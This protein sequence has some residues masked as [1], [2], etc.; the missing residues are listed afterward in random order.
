MT[1]RLLYRRHVAD[2]ML[3]GILLAMVLLPAA[4]L[5][6]LPRAAAL[7]M[8]MP[9]S[10]LPRDGLYRRERIPGEV[11]FFSWTD[12]DSLLKPPNPGG[13]IRLRVELLSAAQEPVGV[14]MRA[15]AMTMH[16]VVRPE[17]RSYALL[18]PPADGERIA[19]ALDSPELQAHKRWIG[20]GVGDINIAG[21]GGAPGQ[22]LLTLAVATVGGYTLLRQSRWQA[23]TAGSIVFSLHML[24]LCWQLAGGWR[25]GLL[26]VALAL[27]GGAGL[28]AVAVE[29]WRSAGAALFG[30]ATP[31]L[32]VGLG[33]RR[34][35]PTAA[36]AWSRR[37]AWMVALL[38]AAALLVCLPFLAARDPVGDLELSARRMSL[39]DRLG[40]AG[41]Y[42]G[43]GDYLPLR[44]YLLLGLGKLAPL[45]GGF[46]TP[47][48]QSTPP[49]MLVLLKLPGLLAHLATVALLY[50]WSRRWRSPRGAAL[51]AALY[52][53]APPVWINVAWWGQVDALLMLPLLGA[54]VLLD[55][56]GGRW[57]WL[58][59]ATALLIKSQAILLAPLLFLGT[60]GRY[61]CRGLVRGAS[62]AVGVLLAGWA[63]LVLAGQA[64]GL[65]EA[66]AGSVERFP[67]T[68][69]AAYNLWFLL[70]G[71]ESTRDTEPW[72]LG[73][74]YRAAG[75]LLLGAAVLLVGLALL[76]RSDGPAR[77]EAAAVLALAFFCLP[78]Q[79]HER[80]LF[81]TLAFLVARSASAPRLLGLY[82]LL[83]TT[84]TLNIFGELKGFIPAVYASLHAS[85]LPLLLA[86]INLLLCIMLT[87]H[88]LLVTSKQRV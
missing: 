76:R 6:R 2:A 61:G 49:A 14:Q 34:S 72:W 12:G 40:L 24:A 22:V 83:L 4:L 11:S 69:V 53:L 26:V 59:W 80:Y 55:R 68:G 81:L 35:P 60:L 74:S 75:L 7:T 67:R 37:D 86:P 65:A 23:R 78:T 44:L 63:P 43:D 47:D 15:G 51:I 52:A 57:S 79:I 84:A 25:Y 27:A 36:V 9:E 58:A 62:L 42:T 32:A 88:L 46:P 28:A 10:L 71:G 29:R 70:L 77:V 54:V 73:L 66:Y 41:A 5:Y 39:L 16:F 31:Q 82:L 13:A 3:L 20:V 38:L 45:L 87:G 50:W 19:L 48:A 64:P 1:F 21:G 18:L 8:D 56:R 85:S 30:S 33:R 17:P